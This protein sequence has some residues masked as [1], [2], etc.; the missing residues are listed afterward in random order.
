MLDRKA[1]EMASVVKVLMLYKV[2]AI[3]AVRE[4]T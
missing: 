3:P 2:H 1:T 4:T